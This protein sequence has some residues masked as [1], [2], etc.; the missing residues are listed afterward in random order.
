MGGERERARGERKEEGEGGGKKR[1][2]RE[3]RGEWKLLLSLVVVITHLCGN[4]YL[5]L[6]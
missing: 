6:W 5:L 2:K 1:G 4:C 3:G